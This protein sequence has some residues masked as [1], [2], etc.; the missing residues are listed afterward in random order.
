MD[1]EQSE[2]Q[3]MIGDS[4]DLFGARHYPSA[5]RLKRLQDG[6]EVVADRW[7]EMAGLGWPAL[8][9]GDANAEDDGYVMTLMQG[10]GRHLML[11]PYVTRCI[12]VPALLDAATGSAADIRAGVADGRVQAALAL[13][14]PQAGFNLARVDTVAEAVGEE[15][16]LS[17]VKSHVED[18]AD[19]EWFV[20]PARIAG[21]SDDA[22]GISLFLVHRDA[23]GL[24]IDRFRSIDGHRHAR[25]KLD[26][27]QVGKDALVAPPEEGLPRLEAAVDRAIVAHLA[28]ALGSMD[29]VSAVAL[30][31]IKT[32]QQFG[33]PIGSF[34][35]L[36]HRMVDIDTAC[37]EARS[38]V[39]HATA[40]LRADPATRRQ[41]VSAAKARV[42]QCGLFVARQ[43]IQLHGGVG[44]SAE[45]IVSHHLKRQMML[46]L[47]YGN[48]AYHRARFAEAFDLA[49]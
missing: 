38:M 33:K 10:F 21:L 25:L 22:A 12:L 48:A 42:G 23:S 5:L 27:V 24:A 7:V 40:K 45:L 49:A 8:G 9:Q 26:G 19:A 3:V 44:V 4:V 37:E 47:A 36:Q 15:Y 11:E 31:Y 1:F 41:A 2:E 46:D 17:G 20:V 13:G 30:D 29:A 16:R 32:R 34:Q 6:P 43:S 14:E 35:V 18:G 28:E 39:Y